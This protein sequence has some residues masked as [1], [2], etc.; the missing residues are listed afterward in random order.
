MDLNQ[1][2]TDDALDAVTWDDIHT[3][4][5]NFLHTPSA[6]AFTDWLDDHLGDRGNDDSTVRDVLIGAHQEWTGADL[7]DPDDQ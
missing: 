5:S 3:W 6:T 7:P 1:P 4:A 2:A